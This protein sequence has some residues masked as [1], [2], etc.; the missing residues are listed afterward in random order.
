VTGPA[1]T[2]LLDCR[3]E[4]ALAHPAGSGVYQLGSGSTATLHGFT[5]TYRHGFNTVDDPHGVGTTTVNGVNDHG[6]LVGFYV[7]SASN[8]DGMLATPRH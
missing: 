8:T 1:A 4:L 5:W 2:S 7:D 6:D 3:D